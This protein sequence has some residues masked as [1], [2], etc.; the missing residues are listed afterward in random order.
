MKFD[1]NEN[2]KLR[3]SRCHGEKDNVVFE[4]ANP[5]DLLGRPKPDNKYYVLSN[6]DLVPNGTSESILQSLNDIVAKT[7]K[8]TSKSISEC[9]REA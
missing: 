6:G 3:Y 5:L 4:L 9:V 2:H 7:D 1:Q 8:S